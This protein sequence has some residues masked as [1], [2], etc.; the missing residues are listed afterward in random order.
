VCEALLFPKK[1][2][3]KIILFCKKC[4]FEGEAKRE[5]EYKLVVNIPHSDSEKIAVVEGSVRKK[6][7]EEEREAFEDYYRGIESEEEGGGEEPEE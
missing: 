6:I 5:T 2:D 4:G 3:G 1:E 7:S